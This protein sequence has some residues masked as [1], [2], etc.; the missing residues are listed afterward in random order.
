[1]VSR[2]EMAE[3]V[4]GVT[5]ELSGVFSLGDLRNLLEPPNRGVFY[6]VLKDL[7][8]AGIVSRFCR[9][10][11]VAQG[12]DPLVLSQRLDPDSYISFGNVLARHLLVGSVPRYRVRAVKPGPKRIY[13]NGEIQIEHLRLQRDLF[14][15]YEVAD[16]I[17]MASPEKAVLD[18]LYFYRQ[19]VRFSFDVYTDID[20]S[21]LDVDTV[22]SYLAAY[23]S[24]V[25]VDF[26]RRL[27][28]A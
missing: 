20:Y 6:R 16:G 10:F 24:P 11:Y 2:I 19:G 15:G 28:H 4:K 25:F 5:T 8:S 27:I 17:R 23:K 22:R 26:A 12:F 13:R 3:R 14:F 9:G 21:R 1:M 18:T 7:E